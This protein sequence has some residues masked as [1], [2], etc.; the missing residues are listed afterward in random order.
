MTEMG[1]F[2]RMLQETRK[3]LDGVRSGAAAPPDQDAPPAEGNGE[4]A[5][6]RVKAVAVTG[7]RLK[8]IELDPRMMRL[9]SAELAEHIVTAVNAALAD[10]R[11]KA[12]AEDAAIDPE[13]LARHVRE[14]QDQSLRQMAMFT[15]TISETVARINQGR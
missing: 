15:Q 14:V 3:M 11:A 4:A 13:A 2:D 5:D 6:G 1:E 8:S 10:L 12:T 9:A 7:G